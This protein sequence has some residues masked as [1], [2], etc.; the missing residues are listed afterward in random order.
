LIDG[1]NIKLL[2]FLVPGSKGP[3]TVTA[4]YLPVHG[5]VLIQI[6]RQESEQTVIQGFGQLACFVLLSQGLD[7]GLDAS[8]DNN[9]ILY[10]GGS[11][12]RG[13][14]GHQSHELHHHYF[15]LVLFSLD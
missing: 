7:Y 5:D 4:V 11:E 1:G 15:L 9:L 6:R 13:H 2:R 12:K 14:Q 3:T 8:F 10:R